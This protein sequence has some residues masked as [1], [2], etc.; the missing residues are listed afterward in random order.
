MVRNYQSYLSGT[1]CIRSTGGIVIP[2]T[3]LRGM[4][5]VTLSYHGLCYMAIIHL[6]YQYACYGRWKPQIV[7]SKT[8]VTEDTNHDSLSSHCLQPYVRQEDIA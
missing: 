1:G 8:A 7:T 5:T 2:R 6:S 3:L 4:G